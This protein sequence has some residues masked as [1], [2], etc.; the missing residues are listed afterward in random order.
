[1]KTL[2][3]NVILL[4]VIFI[5]GCTITSGQLSTLINLTQRPDIILSQNAWVVNYKTY[6]SIVYAVNFSDGI[7]FSNG[8]GDQ[9]LFDGWKV[10]KISGL[11]RRGLD[12]K[13]DEADGVRTFKQ[14]I[15]IIAN[16]MCQQWQRYNSHNM[17]SLSQSCADGR[18]YTNSI[19]I[20]DDGSISFIRQIVDDRYTP[21][22]LTKVE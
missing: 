16:H 18:K 5:Q 6:E 13:I 3:I 17:V 21:L 14:G 11:G 20:I 2:M 10:R 15:R 19:L 7:L 4:G 12:I 8:T 22:T 9:I 1:M